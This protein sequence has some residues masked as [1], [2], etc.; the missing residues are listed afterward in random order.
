VVVLALGL[1]EGI[2]SA[3]LIACAVWVLAYLTVERMPGRRRSDEQNVGLYLIQLGVLGA[4]VVFLT[5]WIK[6][7]F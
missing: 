5:A 4:I 1:P 7:S 2:A 6:G 3:I